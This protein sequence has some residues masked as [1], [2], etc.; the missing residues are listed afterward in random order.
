MDTATLAMLVAAG[1]LGITVVD[2]IWTGSW[3]LSGKLAKMEKGLRA[4]IED[5]RKEIEE[6]QRRP[7]TN[8]WRHAHFFS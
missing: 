3:N 4:A 1:G 7:H 2:K 6:R 8:G 5:S